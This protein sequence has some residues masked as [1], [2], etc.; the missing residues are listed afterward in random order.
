MIELGTILR[1]TESVFISGP[2]DDYSLGQ[3][4]GLL[5]SLVAKLNEITTLK[6]IPMVAHYNMRRFD[7]LLLAQRAI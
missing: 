5:K 3:N 6:V 4:I 2:R 1:K 7:E